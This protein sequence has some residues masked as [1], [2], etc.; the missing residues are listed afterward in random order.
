MKV[1]GVGLI[2]TGTKTLG[3]CLRRWGLKHI[4][5][6]HEAFELWRKGE[7]ETLLRKVGEFDSFEDWPWPLV[8]R[9]ID[10]EFPGTR[11]ILT[12]RKDAK[13]WFRSV[14]KHAGRTGPTDYRKYVFGHEMPYGREKEHIQFYESHLRSVRAYFKDRPGDLLEV[15]WEDGSGWAEL[16]AFLGF[17]PPDAPFPHL[18]KS[19]SRMDNAKNLAR[20]LIKRS[21]RSAPWPLAS[22]I[23]ELERRRG[24]HKHPS[25]G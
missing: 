11:F 21:L 22:V 8:Y 14:C 6:D 18:N 12:R 17:E 5:R 7:I 2:K 20:R 1:V 9:E 3:V 15:C 25:G 19:P 4:S 23:T 24:R 16:A 10:R 13:T